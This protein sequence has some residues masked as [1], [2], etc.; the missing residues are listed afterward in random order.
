MEISQ[1]DQYN[2]QVK[3]QAEQ[4]SRKAKTLDSLIKGLQEIANL[5]T[6]VSARGY[7]MNLSE[8]W[9]AS[10]GDVGPSLFED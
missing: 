6:D 4:W 2:E 7:I 3:R 8:A 1:V 10:G 9:I 5:A